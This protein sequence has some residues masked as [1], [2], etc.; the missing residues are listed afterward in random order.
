M[1]LRAAILAGLATLAFA[2]AARAGSEGGPIVVWPT[3]T[4]AGDEASP[5]PLHKPTAMEV[6]LSA[7]A[8]ELDATLRDAVQDLG[9]SLDVADPGPAPGHTRDQDLLDRASKR[10]EAGGTWVVS[11]RLE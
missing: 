4:P 11:A 10:T 8:Q 6:Q 1:R 9:Y 5:V 3:L 7:R 2:S